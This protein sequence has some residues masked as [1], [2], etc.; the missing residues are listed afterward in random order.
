MDALVTRIRELYSDFLAADSRQ[1]AEIYAEN[2]VFRDPV[3]ELCGLASLQGYFAGMAENLQECR[4]EFDQSLIDGGRV[5]LWWT[6]YYRHPRL[7]GGSPLKLR[8]ASLLLIDPQLNRVVMHEDVYDLGAMV[9]EQ[10]P[11]LG[12]VVNLVKASLAKGSVTAQASEKRIDEPS[13]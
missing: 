12:R 2:T 8:G 9:Y 3:H 11:V 5:S 1:I 7:G 4:F 13:N 6:M 10:I